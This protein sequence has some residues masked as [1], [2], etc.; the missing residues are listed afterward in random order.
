MK[1]C[2]HCHKVGH[3]SKLC[4]STTNKPIPTR[5]SDIKPK[6]N[7]IEDSSNDEA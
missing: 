3:F 1:E 6:I 4:K 5:K 7:N 2:R